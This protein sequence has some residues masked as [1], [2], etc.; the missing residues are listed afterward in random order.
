[1][2]LSHAEHVAAPIA[3]ADMYAAKLPN[4]MCMQNASMQ[5]LSE[6]PN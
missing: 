4:D 3:A 2:P 6:I 5:N 1:M